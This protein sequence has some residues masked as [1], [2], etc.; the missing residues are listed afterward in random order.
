MLVLVLVIGGFG[1]LIVC[2]PRFE[3]DRVASTETRAQQ[4]RSA[5]TMY[6]AE[7]PEGPCPGTADLVEGGFLDEDKAPEDVWG[8]ELRITC[9]GTRL[10]VSSAG[11]DGVFGTGDDID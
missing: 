3:P 11:P 6:L 9:E 10:K 7:N 4:V 1:W 5:V 2:V 8:G